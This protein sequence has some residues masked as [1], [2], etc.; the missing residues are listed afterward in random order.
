M[1]IYIDKA[2]TFGFTNKEGFYATVVESVPQSLV[3]ITNELNATAL[4]VGLLVNANFTLAGDQAEST[5]KEIHERIVRM[6]GVID[7]IRS[8]GNESEE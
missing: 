7:S 1:T 2:A 4:D 5:A 3:D 6:L 8:G